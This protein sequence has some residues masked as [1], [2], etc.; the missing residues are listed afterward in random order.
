M[1][2]HRVRHDWSDLAAAALEGSPNRLI[3]P[4]NPT[5]P[6]GHQATLTSSWMQWA[7]TISISANNKWP[8]EVLSIPVGLAFSLTST[9]TDTYN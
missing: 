2:S 6:T 1:G 4:S 5:V 7:D 8:G 9:D 3:L